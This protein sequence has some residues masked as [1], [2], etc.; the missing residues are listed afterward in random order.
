[1]LMVNLDFHFKS[2]VFLFIINEWKCIEVGVWDDL[3][4]LQV[5]S[6]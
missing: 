6:C 5:Y 1:M 2:L 3:L 4:Q